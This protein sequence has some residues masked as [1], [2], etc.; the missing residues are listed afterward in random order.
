MLLTQYLRKMLIINSA[1]RYVTRVSTVHRVR[2]VYLFSGW[3]FITEE[4]G[5]RP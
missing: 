1:P 3:L 2:Y 5:A 4:A